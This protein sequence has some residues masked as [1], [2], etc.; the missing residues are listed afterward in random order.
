MRENIK[1]KD[2]IIV[3]ILGFTPLIN[4]QSGICLAK[5]E[6]VVDVIVS[7]HYNFKEKLP[8]VFNVIDSSI[9]VSNGEAILKFD[10]NGALEYELKIPDSLRDG[11]LISDFCLSKQGYYLSIGRKLISI[12]KKGD[13]F[14][15]KKDGGYLL[16][17][18]NNLL[19]RNKDIT[20]EILIQSN[21]GKNAYIYPRV[22]NLT[23]LNFEVINDKIMLYSNDDYFYKLPLDTTKSAE[24][25]ELPMLPKEERVWFLGITNN[26]YLFKCY[27]AEIEKDILYTY[28]EHLNFI[29]KII[30]PLDFKDITTKFTSNSE[31]NYL[32][33]HPSGIIYH[34]NGEIMYLM[35]NTK[36]GVVISKIKMG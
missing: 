2:L 10:I 31:N 5:D 19:I 34:Y 11:W 4:A 30:V 9:Y 13:V 23:P 35:R 25:Y 16:R 6:N 3:L 15:S 28:D 7:L 17:E 8:D 32:L 33:E 1:L 18:Y 14:F 26:S 24:K 22:K 20:D 27:D 36:S 12:S 29:K 21:D